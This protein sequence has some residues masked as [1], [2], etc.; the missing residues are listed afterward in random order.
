MDFTKNI[1]IGCIVGDT[2]SLSYQISAIKNENLKYFHKSVQFSDKTVLSMAVA[3]SLMNST[4]YTTNLKKFSYSDHGFLGMTD[5]MKKWVRSSGK[6]SNFSICNSVLRRVAPVGFAVTS[7]CEIDYFARTT[8]KPTHDTLESITASKII[9]TAIYYLNHGYGKKD[10][11]DLLSEDFR[12]FNTDLSNSQYKQDIYSPLLT[13]N[14][15]VHI[16]LKG[17]GFRD[18]IDTC[19]S[20]SLDT[21]AVLTGALNMA[22]YK[23]IPEEMTQNVLLK[24][25]AKYVDIAISFQEWLEINQKKNL[26]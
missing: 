19:N 9:M 7:K 17:K 4:D 5:E 2:E 12:E 18:C 13:A 11:I 22:Y 3:F 1:L 20:F 8:C 25:S 26:N 16:F 24:L 6:D 23:E 15:A 14:N 21:E 10:L